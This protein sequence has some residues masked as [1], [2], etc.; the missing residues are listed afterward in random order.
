MSYINPVLAGWNPDPS[1]CRAG[2]NYYLATS[3]F[4][5]WPGC[6]IYH[7]RDL[8]HWNLI[9]H[10]LTRESQLSFARG[11]GKNEIFAPTLRYHEGIFY[12]IT[13]D[14][15][16]IG[17]FYVTATDPAGPW[18]DPIVVEG[19][20]FD[21]SLLFD[22]DG[23]VYY[24]R[25][26]KTGIVQAPID[27]S[28]GKLLAPL[29][30]IG[31]GYVSTDTEG[32]HLYKIHGRYYLLTGEGGSRYGHMAA[33]GRSDSP[34][35]P[36]EPCPHNPIL[37]QRHITFSP[38]RDTGHAELLEDAQGRWWL[39]FLG[40]RN[41]T[42]SSFAHLG[43]E[44]HLL[45]VDW[46]ENN[47]PVMAEAGRAFPLVGGTGEGI[48]GP[49]LV[50]GEAVDERDDWTSEALHGR[51]LTVRQPRAE[52]IRWGK[53]LRNHPLGLELDC[54]AEQLSSSSVPILLA[55]RL[56][57]FFFQA[58]VQVSLQRGP[59]D[60]P[61]NYPQGGGYQ[62]RAGLCLYLDGEHYYS[63]AI[64]AEWDGTH[65]V[66]LTKRVEDLQE[67]SGTHTLP[68][69]LEYLHLGIVGTD[70]AFTFRYRLGPVEEWVELGTGRTKLLWPE[71]AGQWT[72]MVIGPFAEGVGPKSAERTAEA[73]FR[74]W[75]YQEEGG[76]WWT[77]D[78]TIPQRITEGTEA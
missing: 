6:P 57:A 24:T 46:D 41:W 48:Q 4:M 35:G 5:Y 55:R 13:T 74:N 68:G 1:A 73:H 2:D 76:R 58:E 69:S 44:T 11:P 33:I 38:I 34:W 51:W 31:R 45:P 54:G 39:F 56:G 36:F 62:G 32:P 47:W 22:D 78:G 64:Q 3:T 37:T 72:G 65:T 52:S 26:G 12:L 67:L 30:E 18:S 61:Q 63:L 49:D 40:T 71:L 70:K 27:I 59:Q 42:Y 16:G 53:A 50:N 8:V 7:S 25:R 75:R 66:C 21:P 60:S 17:N 77:I 14:V 20:L 15:G 43:R 10:A 28:T 19:G 23:M 29:R 9:G